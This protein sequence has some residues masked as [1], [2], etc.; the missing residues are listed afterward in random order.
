[1][2]P[3]LQPSG[4]SLAREP[5]MSAFTALSK[6]ALGKKQGH[7]SEDGAMES[8]VSML[9]YFC[10]WFSDVRCSQRAWLRTSHGRRYA[11][12][13]CANVGPKSFSWQAQMAKEME[14]TKESN[15]HVNASHSPN[16]PPQS[17]KNDK[18]Y[19]SEFFYLSVRPSQ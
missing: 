14:M 2:V 6:E 16:T 5:W 10:L 9:L 4:N 11:T 19:P 8:P 17:H 7:E 13:V 18:G 1:M 15:A 3:M 12:R